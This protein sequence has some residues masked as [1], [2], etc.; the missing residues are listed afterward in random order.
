LI[1]GHIPVVRRRLAT[2]QP[3]VDV[4]EAEELCNF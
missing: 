3:P 4:I 2:L 1:D